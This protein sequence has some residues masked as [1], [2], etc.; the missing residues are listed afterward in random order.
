MSELILNL[1]DFSSDPTA[2]LVYGGGGHGKTLLE[3]IKAM[4]SYRVV[5]IIDDKLEA[6]ASILGAPVLGNAD[7][8]PYCYQRGLHLAVNSVGGIGYVEARLKVFEILDSFHFTCP[9]IVH[10]TAWVE[11]SAV[12]EPGVQLLAHTYVGSDC[13]V[14]FGSVLN[15]GVCLSH[16]VITGK[17]TNFSPGAQLGGNVSVGDY[18][19]VGMNATI[20]LGV[21]VGAR[22]RIGNGATVKKD[23]PD[24]TV[25][26]AGTIYPPRF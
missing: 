26:Y 24:K 9:T 22:V 5:G 18:T 7:A 15:V 6:G 12:L 16:D 14:G 11:D 4:R 17:V 23:V 3:L 20:N 19:Q 8:L 1:P 25:V 13:R 21:K 2:I 10:P